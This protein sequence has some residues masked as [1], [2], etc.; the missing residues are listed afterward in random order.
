MQRA[1]K[2]FIREQ[3]P[4]QRRIEWLR[5]EPLACNSNNTHMDDKG[6]D[7]VP[8]S[9]SINLS[10]QPSNPRL[11]PSSGRFP[12]S[13]T[14]S[15]SYNFLA[16]PARLSRPTPLC[17]LPLA[18]LA[19]IG[20]LQAFLASLHSG[21]SPEQ[22]SRQN[23]YN[24]FRAVFFS[25]LVASILVSYPDVD[26]GTSVAQH[27]EHCHRCHLTEGYISMSQC[28][29]K[30]TVRAAL[31]KAASSSFPHS[32]QCLRWCRWPS[33]RLAFASLGK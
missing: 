10:L 29:E 11:L 28:C 17:P 23:S 4:Q 32:I 12:T 25:C 30:R 8:L 22:C 21:S 15:S 9:S 26:D 6:R 3:R 27:L 19:T 1:V 18:L 5:H 16:L 2:A 13:I 20:A 7:I 14:S 31:L 33:R 24:D